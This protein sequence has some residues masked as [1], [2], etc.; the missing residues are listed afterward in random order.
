[1]GTK[2][3][4]HSGRY[5]GH[6]M[7]TFILLASILFLIGSFNVRQ[8]NSL[9]TYGGVYGEMLKIGNH[10]IYGT[11]YSRLYITNIND[12]KDT[13]EIDLNIGTVAPQ[14]AKGNYV[15]TI[16]GDT[17]LKINYKNGKTAWSFTSNS[18]YAFE[19]S[20]VKNGRVFITSRDGALYVLDSKNGDIIWKKR[21]DNVGKSL[22]RD[23]SDSVY[24][25]PDFWLKGNYVYLADR[26][27]TFYSLNI[28]NGKEMWKFKAE[29]PL[30]GNFSLYKT[31]I[32]IFT[33][34][35]RTIFLDRRSGKVN[36]QLSQDRPTKCA[37]IYKNNLMQL[38]TSG[39][40][41]YRK[42]KDGQIIWETEA[43][44][45][46]V[47]C[48]YY[49]NDNG[50]MAEEGGTVFRINMKSGRTEWIKE[51][52]GKIKLPI[53]TYKHNLLEKGY[54][55]NNSD[56]NV[57]SINKS[58]NINW[59][60]E[61]FSP[62]YSRILT[63]RKQIFIGTSSAQIYKINKHTGRPFKKPDLLAYKTFYRSK[64]VGK[65][66]IIE[67]NL[68][69]R[70]YFGTP[71]TEG[72]LSAELTS[73]SGR[74]I[75]VDGFYDGKNIWMIR[76]NPPEKG[77][78]LYKLKWNDHGAIY[79]KQGKF[80]AKTDT[81]NTYLRVNNV[82]PKRLTI[83]G[84]TI[85]NGVGIQQT[86][87]DNNKNGTPLD[88]WNIGG[89]DQIVALDKFLETYG[90][91]GSGINIYRYGNGNSND[92]LYRELGNPTVYS[93]HQGTVVDNFMETLREQ[94]IHI[95][96]S[97]FHFDIP[98]SHPL[99]E[100]NKKT[101][102]SYIRYI[103][104]RYGAYVDI[105]EIVNEYEAPSAIKS[106]LI[107]EI[108][109]YDFEKRLITTSPEDTTTDGIDIISPHWYESENLS[110]S[111]RRT[112]DFIDEFRS[113]N[114]PVIFGEQGNALENWDN[115]SPIRMRV[116]LWTAFFR[117]AIMIFWSSSSTKGVSQR[118]PLYANI[119]LGEEERF[120]IKNLQNFTEGF[121]L[122]SGVMEFSLQ[123]YGIRGNGLT[124][125]NTYAGYFFNFKN[126]GKETSFHYT[127]QV[128]FKGTLQWYDP[129]TG[130]II[131][132]DNCYFDIC[133]LSSPLFKIDIA[134]KLVKN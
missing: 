43:F 30:I 57:W 123:N 126:P 19:K 18:N 68:K 81:S 5:R 131:R 125:K 65:S 75:K 49:F 86:M 62:I 115:E 70:S 42:V 84:K 35:G 66:Q 23:S 61:T 4:K 124:S 8:W 93:L 127:F 79:T 96:F 134:F 33:S 88:D 31:G 89:S 119:Y 82:N 78:W 45:S 101:I 112:Y 118:L 29:N 72:S 69:S 12:T 122:E 98:Y 48:P 40:V 59:M 25:S 54:I 97:F 32:F 133:E 120:Y 103:I 7:L 34:D 80:Y 11:D 15:Y 37:D 39:H 36:W 109:R 76:F 102:S 10:I 27:G 110:D 63:D 105:W 74:M 21:A 14:M 95:I 94:D 77:V 17:Y 24:Y 44:G 20:E 38:D 100:V 50:V 99:N 2:D 106:F 67:I 107:D 41:V 71:W 83:D 128:P 130:K 26:G 117:E 121:P 51:G 113:I 58:S 114:K 64:F 90:P 60:F 116:R 16:S 28:R 73:P 87:L 129:E 3:K 47:I 22:L 85:F 9:T 104:A 52:F 111:D 13:K 46:K 53:I 92:F 108:K 132:E 6:R 91:S 56:G 1:M 55:L